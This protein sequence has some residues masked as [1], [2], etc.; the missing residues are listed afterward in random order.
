MFDNLIKS[1]LVLFEETLKSKDLLNYLKVSR[2]QSQLAEE[3]KKV[4]KTQVDLTKTIVQTKMKYELKI[5]QLQERIDR[6]VE[7][8]RQLQLHLD[9]F[10]C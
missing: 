1:F 4:Q 6:G 10:K 3:T 7:E 9:E 2:L 5:S 8:K